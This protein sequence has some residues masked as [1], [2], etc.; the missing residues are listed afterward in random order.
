[1]ILLLFIC[2]LYVVVCVHV[3]HFF[4]LLSSQNFFRRAAFQLSWISSTLPERLLHSAHWPWH[5]PNYSVL[6]W[7]A[8]WLVAST[9]PSMSWW[10]KYIQITPL[11]F[12]NLFVR[13][14]VVVVVA[15][16]VFYSVSLHLTRRLVWGWKKKTPFYTLVIC[17][18][19]QMVSHW[20]VLSRTVF[21]YIW[22]FCLDEL[23]G[24]DRTQFGRLAWWTDDPD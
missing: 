16:F 4:F 12:Q 22:F 15:P 11:S 21:F 9:R 8:V 7:R 18:C 14:V 13:V 2:Y 23:I 6:C 10:N 3:C 5:F 1:M 20:L 17:R 19:Q 24:C